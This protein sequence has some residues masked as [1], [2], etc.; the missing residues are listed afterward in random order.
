[1]SGPEDLNDLARERLAA[2]VDLYVPCETSQEY[3]DAP[4]WARIRLDQAYMERLLRVR[5]LCAE[6]Q[7]S[8]AE[9][10]GWPAELDETGQTAWKY[11]TMRLDQREIWLYGQTKTAG[12]ARSRMVPIEGLCVTLNAPPAQAV[13]ATFDLGGCCWYGGAI[14]YD[15]DAE[16]LQ[17]FIEVLDEALP[18]LAARE[19]EQQM[20]QVLAERR[21][22]PEPAASPPR[23]RAPTV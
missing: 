20:A 6:T 9:I 15:D 10:K 22:D 19:R 1:M 23:R 21:G 14:V 2:G 5:T 17:E 8:M 4:Q 16:Q 3:L 7:L 11:W 12:T 13:G 18:A